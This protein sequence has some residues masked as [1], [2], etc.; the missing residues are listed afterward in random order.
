MLALFNEI[1]D[2]AGG[3]IQLSKFVV[4]NRGLLHG[5]RQFPRISRFKTE[6]LVLNMEGG[7]QPC[8]PSKA[9]VGTY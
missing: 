1:I 4:E 6:V 3:G 5:I 8:G 7:N 9:R 2:V